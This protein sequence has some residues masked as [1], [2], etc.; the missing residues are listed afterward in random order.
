MMLDTSIDC[1]ASF[2]LIL[3][4]PKTLFALVF[5]LCVCTTSFYQWVDMLPF[6]QPLSQFK[7]PTRSRHLQ[8]GVTGQS[9]DGWFYYGSPALYYAPR[10]REPQLAME[11]RPI[12][13]STSS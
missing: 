1:L 9:P 7:R 3:K 5:F 6:D 12:D 10:P 2:V 11:F 4:E 13:S 8:S